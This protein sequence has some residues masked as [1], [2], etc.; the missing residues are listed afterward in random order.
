MTALNLKQITIQQAREGELLYVLNTS[1]RKGVPP[2]TVNFTTHNS[3]GQR[4][5]VGVPVTTIPVEL[6]T[7][8]TKSAILDSPEFRNLL[9]ARMLTLV[10]AQAAEEALQ[11]EF[12]QDEIRRVRKYAFDT[13]IVLANSAVPEAAQAAQAE[14]NVSGMALNLANTVDEEGKVLQQLRL[15]K[16]SLTVEDLRYIAQ[17]SVLARVKQEAAQMAIDEAQSGD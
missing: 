3:S 13:E 11:G 2:G 7:M 14:S 16:S 17:V 15:N 12:A 4:N 9:S 1:G 5:V 8:S 6:T 10:D